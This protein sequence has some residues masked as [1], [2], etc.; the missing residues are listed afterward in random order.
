MS[1][2]VKTRKN[3]Y[4]T[5]IIIQEM[6]EQ[7][8]IEA[9]IIYDELRKEDENLLITINKK[10]WRD[11]FEQHTLDLSETKPGD[12][13]RVFGTTFTITKQENGLTNISFYSRNVFDNELIEKRERK[14]VEFGNCGN[15]MRSFIEHSF[16]NLTGASLFA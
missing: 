10:V 2:L 12:T 5:S 14:I 15:A 9:R 16:Y 4:Y 3:K 7:A 13:Y 1:A 6:N 11:F 8:F